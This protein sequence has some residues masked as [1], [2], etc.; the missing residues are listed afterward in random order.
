[1]NDDDFLILNFHTYKIFY[2]IRS[3]VDLF[4]VP[5]QSFVNTKMMD[6]INTGDC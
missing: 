5:S 2:T 3:A 6:M 1:M 4:P